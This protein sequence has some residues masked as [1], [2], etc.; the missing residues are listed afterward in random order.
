M[1]P[2]AYS[3]L[4]LTRRTAA[5]GLLHVAGIGLS[6]VVSATLARLLGAA[7]FGAYT[8]ALTWVSVFATFGLFG[9]D[10]LAVRDVSVHLSQQA[11]G[12]LRGTLQWSHG[13]TAVVSLLLVGGGGAVLAWL[14]FPDQ[15]WLG[16]LASLAIPLLALS[17]LQQATLRGLARPAS[18]QVP[19]LLLRPLLMLAFVGAVLVVAH[20]PLTVPPVLAAYVVTSALAL[21][22]G[23]WLVRRTLPA[24]ARAAPP[25]YAPR[26]W[27][28]SAVHMLLLNGLALVSAQ[29]D[30]LALGLLQGP[31]MVGT[32]SAA[33]RGAALVPLGLHL[34]VLVT[35]P[36]FASLYAAGDRANLQRLVTRTTLLVLLGGLPMVVGMLLFG[37]WFLLL[38]GPDFV[39]AQPALVILCVGQFVN[40]ATGPVANLLTMTGHERQ[41]ILGL[42]LSAVAN[43]VLSL[44]LIPHWGLAGAAL[45]SAASLSLWN[46]VLVVVVHRRLKISPTILGVIQ[47]LLSAWRWPAR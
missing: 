32:Y 28:T 15:P 3:L 1:L 22:G 8:Y 9:V 14:V 39:N 20:R 21:G 36:A 41:V 27:L 47:R 7:D 46:S 13:V 38:Y 2:P 17:R 45:A 24:E 16:V 23:A 19:E 34:T 26:L 4:R 5:V 44:V 18:S 6:F 10:R 31:E 12:W 37:R 35:A 30:T 43:V 29:I 42:S 11:W 33:L 40:I 25:Q